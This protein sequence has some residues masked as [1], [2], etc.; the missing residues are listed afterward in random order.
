MASYILVWIS[1]TTLQKYVWNEI[2]GL[3]ITDE[4]P[5]MIIGDLNELPSVQ[6]KFAS[7]LGNSSRFNKINNFLSRNN[8]VD[9]GSSGLPYTWWNSRLKEK[10]IFE[11]LDRVVANPAWLNSFTDAYVE[12]LPIIGSDHGPILLSIAG[13]MRSL[14]FFLF[15]FEAKWL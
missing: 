12:D 8:L 10:T 9:V 14:R 5:W 3:T 7:N 11:R 15:K 6:E 4:T 2:A 1:S 13:S